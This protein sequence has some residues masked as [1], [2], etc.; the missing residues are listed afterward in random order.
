[1]NFLNETK[2]LIKQLNSK[3]LQELVSWL[4]SYSTNKIK[5]EENKSIFLC[6]FEEAIEQL[7]LVKQNKAIARPVEDLLNEL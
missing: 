4:N 5:E 6:E 7:N 2:E 1:M 3:E